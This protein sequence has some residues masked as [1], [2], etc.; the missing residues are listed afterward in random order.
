[1]GRSREG[2]MGVRRAGRV[3]R[4]SGNHLGKRIKMIWVCV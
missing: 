2:G 1:M 3:R 4:E